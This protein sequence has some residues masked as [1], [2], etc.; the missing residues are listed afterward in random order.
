MGRGDI[1]P[2]PSP[3]RRFI[4][5]VLRLAKLLRLAKQR[6]VSAGWPAAACFT[7]TP[8][9]TTS[10]GMASRQLFQV[11]R[12]VRRH[13]M[14]GGRDQRRDR[15]G[16]L[17]IRR[18]VRMNQDL[19]LNQDLHRHNRSVT[20]RL[21]RRVYQTAF[22][23]TLWLV[24]ASWLFFDAGPH[25]DSYLIPITTLFLVIMA[26][27]LSIW[28]VW[29]TVG[30]GVGREKSASLREWLSGDFDA[31]RYRLR[32]SEAAMQVLLPI[33]A[34]AIGIT[35]IGLVAHFTLYA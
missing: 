5:H 26:V 19:R 32:A 1:G 31:R 29:S 22:G 35:A 7:Q 4:S 21:H 15:S 12:S 27:P 13:D 14:D 2:R 30:P 25:A 6:Q 9:F 10:G 20:D 33:V 28:W 11:A 23:L 16:R 17:R 34:A 24:V 18:R 8:E 3:R